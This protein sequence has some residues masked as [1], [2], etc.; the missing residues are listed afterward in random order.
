[1]ITQELLQ[2]IANKWYLQERVSTIPNKV[3]CANKV[4]W[5]KNDSNNMKSIISNLSFILKNYSHFSAIV[6]KL[7]QH[8]FLWNETEA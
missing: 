7:W 3:L 8:C 4:L 6:N 2:K 5:A 1:M